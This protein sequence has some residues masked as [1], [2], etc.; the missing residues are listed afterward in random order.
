MRI[1]LA[2]GLAI[3][4]GCSQLHSQQLEHFDLILLSLNKKPD[5][6]WHPFAP[7]FLTQF[8][9]LGYNNQPHFFSPTE[10]YLTVQD[11]ADTTQTEL[12]ALNLIYRTTTRIT[13]T[14]TPEY[15]PTLMPD[16]R[17]FSAVR[18]EADGSQRLWAFPKDRSDNGQRLFPALTNIG[19]H[20]WL[21]DTLAALFLVGQDNAPHALAIVGMQQ[22]QARK[23]AFNIG[24]CLQK[25]PDGRLAYV[26]KATENTWFI[27]AYDP[28][29]NGS[30]ILSRTLAGSEDFVVLQDGTFLAGKGSK[31]Y[32]YHPRRQNDWKEIADLSKNGVKSITRLAHS[33]DG[34]LVIVVQ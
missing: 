27:K 21:R 32:Q 5:S 20:C 15:S 9:P 30:D 17:R 34:K 8:N 3:V 10:L 24:R 2:A 28:E 1:L 33:A 16:G 23:I 12:Y 6:T 7:R 14:T 13:A 11:P 29:R 26:H 31:L 19:Y 18:V 4:L 22:Q 25:M